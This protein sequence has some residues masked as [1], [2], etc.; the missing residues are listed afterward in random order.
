MSDFSS[1]KVKDTFKNVLHVDG[2]TDDSGV[3]STLRDVSDGDG[4]TTGLQLSDSSTKTP[5]SQATKLSVGP[6]TEDADVSIS[7]SSDQQNSNISIGSTGFDNSK[8]THELSGYICTDL[9]DKTG[10][11]V[12]EIQ[13]P[14][15]TTKGTAWVELDIWATEGNHLNHSLVAGGGSGYSPS[16]P[17]GVRSFPRR[18][19]DS[20][21]SE[22]NGAWIA[23]T[24][25]S[26]GDM[27]IHWVGNIGYQFRCVIAGVTGLNYPVTSLNSYT[28]WDEVNDGS[29]TWI[30]IGQTADLT[31]VV[32]IDEVTDIQINDDNGPGGTGY[33]QRLKHQSITGTWYATTDAINFWGPTVSDSDGSAVDTIIEPLSVSGSGMAATAYLTSNYWSEYYHMFIKMT[34]GGNGYSTGDTFKVSQVRQDN[35]T[36]I[37][38]ATYT[39]DIS[40]GKAPDYSFIIEVDPPVS[41]DTCTAQV[42]KEYGSGGYSYGVGSIGFTGLISAEFNPEDF[43]ATGEHLSYGKYRGFVMSKGPYD[44]SLGTDADEDGVIEWW[45]ANQSHLK[46]GAFMLDKPYGNTPLGNIIGLNPIDWGRYDDDAG[47]NR[48]QQ[49]SQLMG[50]LITKAGSGSATTLNEA[51]PEVRVWFDYDNSPKVDMAPKIGGDSDGDSMNY[52]FQTTYNSTGGAAAAKLL[53]AQQAIF[54]Y[55]SFGAEYSTGRAT[56]LIGVTPR[57]ITGADILNYNGANGDNFPIPEDSNVGNFYIGFDP[58][59]SNMRTLGIGYQLKIYTSPGFV[60]NVRKVAFNTMSGVAW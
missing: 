25:I 2:T 54:E 22:G 36:V 35:S 52:L 21:F 18:V 8:I 32:T 37:R 43:E 47:E 49:F 11:S 45:Q 56:E 23:A 12:L 42:Q 26:N 48:E 4:T 31:A 7:L 40:G 38:T 20:P 5:L 16:A 53:A 50:R 15:D 30:Y 28:Y 3:D 33:I 6:M 60:I 17:P 14:D 46:K 57:M 29:V 39:V 44:T 24:V 9:E 13:V 51:T 19:A 55:P 59:Y 1:K 58:D 27:F 34:D 10:F 41:G